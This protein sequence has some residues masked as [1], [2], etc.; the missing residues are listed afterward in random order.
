MG[1]SEGTET[2]TFDD[3]GHDACTQHGQNQGKIKG[4]PQPGESQ[5]QKGPE[6]KDVTMCNVEHLKKSQHQG[7]SYGEE[8]IRAT[9]GES[10][11]ELL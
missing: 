5:P 10:V 8:G 4:D 7:E 1:F 9:Q 11:D 6:H 3:N 2:G